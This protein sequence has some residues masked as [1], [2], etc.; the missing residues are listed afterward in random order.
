MGDG[1][2]PHHI[3]SGLFPDFSGT[4]RHI[5]APYVFLHG[6]ATQYRCFANSFAL[7]AR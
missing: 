4:P 7:I 2:S 5:T 6:D 3:R 1:N